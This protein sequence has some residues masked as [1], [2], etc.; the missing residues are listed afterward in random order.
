MESCHSTWNKTQ[1]RHTKKRAETDTHYVRTQTHLLH[2]GY[3]RAVP[4]FYC[5]A[6]DPIC[7]CSRNGSSC[8]HI[9]IKLSSIS[10]YRDRS[11]IQRLPGIQCC[12]ST[13]KLHV[14]LF[15]ANLKPHQNGHTKT[16]A[17]SKANTPS[18]TP[19]EEHKTPLTQIL[20][21]TK[22]DF[23]GAYWCR[24]RQIKL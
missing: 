18:Q 12:Y 11:D 7:N 19:S 9:G 3:A 6:S 2:Y 14:P 4:S 5:C 1:S 8:T 16:P 24:C 23:T 17:H 21:S 20:E 15:N 22:A 10:L 13:G